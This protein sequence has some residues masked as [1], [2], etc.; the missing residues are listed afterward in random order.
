MPR[1]DE[2]APIAMQIDYRADGS[3]A[4]DQTPPVAALKCGGD[5]SDAQDR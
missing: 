2:T 4:S 5:G 1:C 3:V